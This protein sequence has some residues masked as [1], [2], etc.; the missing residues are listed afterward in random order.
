MPKQG[1]KI[2]LPPEMYGGDPASLIE[3]LGLELHRRPTAPYEEWEV[4]LEPIDL[5]ECKTL[6]GPALKRPRFDVSVVP[7]PAVPGGLPPEFSGEINRILG[8]TNETSSL[9]GIL[10][11]IAQT[12]AAV[13][14]ERVPATIEWASRELGQMPVRNSGGSTEPL[15]QQ[16]SV[17]DIRVNSLAYRWSKLP[18]VFLRL[19]YTSLSDLI[20]K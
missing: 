10:E 5:V 3:D 2:A 18:Q 7:T 15:F 13:P 8:R 20:E 11:G 4:S 6:S 9:P 19:Q 12:L 1:M 16:H 14:D 17:H